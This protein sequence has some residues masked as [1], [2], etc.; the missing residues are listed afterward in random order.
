VKVARAKRASMEKSISCAI[1]RVSVSIDL[2]VLLVLLGSG[3][4]PRLLFARLLTR[5]EGERQH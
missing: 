1:A 2:L 5:F 3:R 4:A